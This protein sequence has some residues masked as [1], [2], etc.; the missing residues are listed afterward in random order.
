MYL[1]NKLCYWKLWVLYSVLYFPFTVIKTEFY[2]CLHSQL[3]NT[4]FTTSYCF[5]N[6]IWKFW[7]SVYI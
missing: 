6:T 4:V 1:R 3:E 7:K 2:C 5:P